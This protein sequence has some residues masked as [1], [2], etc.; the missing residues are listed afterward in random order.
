MSA[1]QILDAEHW[2]LPALA[3][4]INNTVSAAEADAKSSM[5]RALEAGKLLTEAKEAVAHGEWQSWLVANCNVAARTAQAYMKLAKRL[6][7]LSAPEAQRVADLPVRDAI[8][9][10]TTD[11]VSP[12]RTASVDTI[13]FSAEKRN[14]AIDIFER[15]NTA[16]KEALRYIRHG[17][18]LPGAKVGALRKK[19][20][21]AIEALDRLA[22]I[23]QDEEGG[24]A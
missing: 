24:A 13:H 1:P 15:S 16:S 19:L 11:P 22:S 17:G 14:A 2:S 6:P 18:R 23:A 21:A 7:E 9:A 5:Q 3:I 20:M 4:K 12:T 8:R 10:I